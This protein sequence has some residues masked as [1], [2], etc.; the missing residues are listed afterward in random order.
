MPPE[1]FYDGFESGGLERWSG[2]NG[3]RRLAVDDLL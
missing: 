2:G 3:T 1:I